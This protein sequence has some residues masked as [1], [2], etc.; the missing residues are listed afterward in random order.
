MRRC[1]ETD[2]AWHIGRLEDEVGLQVRYIDSFKGEEI[3]FIF[4]L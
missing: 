3:E 4:T 2:A 1:P